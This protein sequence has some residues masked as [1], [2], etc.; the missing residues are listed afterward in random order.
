VSKE[1]VKF[2]DVIRDVSGGNAKLP[3][4]EFQTFG[5]LA[6]VDQGQDFVAGYT[7]DMSYKFQ[8]DSL[9]VIVFGDHTRAIKYIDFPFAMGADGVKVLKPTSDCDVKYIFHHLRYADIPSAGY[10]RHYK[11]LKELSFSLP[12]LSEQRRITAILDKAD[13]LRAKRREAIAKLDQ[14]LQSVFLDMFGDPIAN[15][16]GWGKVRMQDLMSISR[17]GSPRPIEKFLGGEHHWIKIGD[18]TKGD[19]V[20]ISETKDKITSEGLSKTTRLKAGSL[21]FANCGVSLGFARILK[22]DGCIHDGWLAFQDIDV[23]R[24]DQLF[25]LKTLNSVT[26]HF[27][28]MAPEGTQ[29]NLNTGIMKRFE[30]IVPPLVQQQK[31]SKFLLECR[32]RKMSLLNGE[33]KTDALFSSLQRAAFSGTL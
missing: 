3:Q 17:G 2:T 10:S 25:L 22:I 20:F 32:L 30:L 1:K 13:A 31:F 18:A 28:K 16:H 19:D 6:V 5:N 7:D 29:P 23:S 8:S 4:S 11:F 24:L 9:P 21:I 26:Q 12:S 33:E 27:R 15:P 14:L